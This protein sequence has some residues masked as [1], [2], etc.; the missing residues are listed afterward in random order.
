MR[1]IYTDLFILDEHQPGIL[2]RIFSTTVSS[3]TVWRIKSVLPA[4]VFFFLVPSLY[5][6]SQNRTVTGTVIDESGA[7]VSG[8]SIILKGTSTGT[9]SDDAGKFTISAPSKGILVLSNVGFDN[10]EVPVRDQSEI[11]VRLTA[12]SESLNQVVV[13]GYGTQKKTSVT[14]AISTLKG[15]DVASTPVTNLSNTLGGRVA[16]VIT[17]QNNGEPGNDASNIFIRGIS[18]TG[19]NQPLLIVDG[20]PRDFKQLDPNSIESFTVLKDAAAVAP[21]GVAG[22]NGVILVTTKSGKTGAPTVTYNGYVGFQNPTVFPNYVSGYEYG[23]LQNAAAKN[24]GLRLSYSEFALQK[25]K[26]GSDPDAS[27]DPNVYRDVIKKNALLTN[28]NIEVSGGTEFI[29]FYA[30]LGLSKPKRYVAIYK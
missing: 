18:S 15:R 14:A 28:H 23:V 10:Q 30:S 27:A 7:P 17:R 13:V 3:K 24:A 19:A 20:I 29:K 12:S 6:F 25:L 22:A 21:Y 26:E 1:Q 4:F 5:L 8:V 9:S 2:N 16:G 11:N